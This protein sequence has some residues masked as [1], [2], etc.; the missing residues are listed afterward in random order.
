MAVRGNIAVPPK[1]IRNIYVRLSEIRECQPGFQETA[2]VSLSPK[3]PFEWFRC[4]AGLKITTT[5]RSQA[6]NTCIIIGHIMRYSL[7]TDISTL[8]DLTWYGK[9]TSV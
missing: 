3:R 6:V 4:F 8:P 1:A 7:K 9:C 2:D 5:H